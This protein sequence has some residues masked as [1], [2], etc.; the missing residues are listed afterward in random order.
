[1]A[2]QW[3]NNSLAPGGNAGWS[4]ARS[5]AKGALPLLQVRLAMPACTCI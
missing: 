5:T 3:G 4:F 1:M 2:A